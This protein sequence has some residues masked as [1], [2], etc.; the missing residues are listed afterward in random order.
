MLRVLQPRQLQER[1]LRRIPAGLSS[2]PAPATHGWAE[3]SA[4]RHPV[5]LKTRRP[6]KQAV[7]CPRTLVPH[8]HASGAF[9][10]EPQVR[11][12][13]VPSPGAISPVPCANVLLPPPA[14]DAG[15]RQRARGLAA[16]SSRP[17]AVFGARRGLPP[18]GGAAP[19]LLSRAAAR[20][21]LGHVVASV[22]WFFLEAR[23]PGRRFLQLALAGHATA[24]APLPPSA[25]VLSS[26]APECAA[27]PATEAQPP[28][29]QPAAAV[30]IVRVPVVPVLAAPS[31]ALPA[32]VP[33]HD[34]AQDARAPGPWP[35]PR[36]GV[37]AFPQPRGALFLASPSTLAVVVREPALRPAA[38]MKAHRH[39]QKNCCHDALDGATGCSQH[40]HRPG[41]LNRRRCRPRR[42]P[43]GRKRK[44]AAGARQRP[45]ARRRPWPCPAPSATAP[46]KL[47]FRPFCAGARFPSLPLGRPAS[48]S[49]ARTS[50]SKGN[51]SSPSNPSARCSTQPRR[52]RWN[53]NRSQP[54]PEPARP[55]ERTAPP[56]AWRQ[57]R[58]HFERLLP[59]LQGL[60]RLSFAALNAWTPRFS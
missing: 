55:R 13:P 58:R 35:L 44:F 11:P 12:P 6:A 43:Q 39:L 40:R 19:P 2:P 45:T 17:A 14:F 18:R 20:A 3:A 56:S 37:H 10:G 59:K 50:C 4:P 26:R 60:G 36:H 9:D 52:S 46:P 21:V 54:P 34:P 1:V 53:P 32:I 51:L 22:A 5:R 27:R 38:A 42:R 24:D 41:P 57:S 47:R 48:S 15:T 7:S 23:R 8:P 49:A 16:D 33:G 28:L 25:A 30:Q 31:H 29:P